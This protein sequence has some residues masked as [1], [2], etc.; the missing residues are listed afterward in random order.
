MAKKS[1]QTIIANHC[2]QV[3]GAITVIVEGL[4]G[5]NF[6][7]LHN[8]RVLDSLPRLHVGHALEVGQT[9]A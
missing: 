9:E 6:L 4:R 2:P 7:D 8:V 1:G 3:G 5:K